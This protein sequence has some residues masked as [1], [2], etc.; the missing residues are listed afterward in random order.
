MS[1]SVPPWELE[2]SLNVMLYVYRNSLPRISRL[3]RPC[4]VAAFSLALCFQIEREYVASDLWARFSSWWRGEGF[5]SYACHTSNCVFMGKIVFS[6]AATVCPEMEGAQRTHSSFQHRTGTIWTN[7]QG[8]EG[9]GFE[10]GGAAVNWLSG[11]IFT[12][13][14]AGFLPSSTTVK[15]L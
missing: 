13:V 12:T 7:R 2:V 6:L 10:G 8:V 9:L 5:I 4:F 1:S 15:S 11:S 14:R 3:L